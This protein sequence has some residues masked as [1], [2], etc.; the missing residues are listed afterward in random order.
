MRQRSAYDEEVHDFAPP[1]AANQTLTCDLLVAGG[2]LSGLSAAEAAL[3]RGLNVV[4]DFAGTEPDATVAPKVVER[5]REQG[6]EP[7]ANP[8]RVTA[9]DL[10]LADLVI[11]L[12]CDLT[13]LSPRE[14][15][16]RNWNDVPAPS[17][18]FGA[19]DAAIL[20]R[21]TAL[22]EELSQARSQPAH[23]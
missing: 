18:D 3:R 12:G 4:V 5:L 13:G 17:A 9:S 22:I 10:A 14:G 8:R 20:S 19:A 7:P 23:R 6:F 16:L 21:V 15:A 11:S 2:G 1:S